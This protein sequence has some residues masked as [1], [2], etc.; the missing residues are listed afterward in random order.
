M[1]V[2]IDEAVN[3]VFDSYPAAMRRK[4]LRLRQLIL[5]TAAEH[6]NI[7]QLQE[8]LK[9]GEP[10]Y[11][12]KGGS[13]IRIAWHESQPDQYAMYFNCRTK[14]VFTFK[15]LF[16]DTFTFDGNRAL[17]FHERDE[18]PVPD[19]KQCILLALTY[20]KRKRLPRLGV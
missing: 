18:I 4:L 7:G 10:S 2:V 1:E 15:D 13:T 20:H 6:E 5:E 14:L 17:V 16:H 3:E 9:W 12:T 8:A 19:L 11:L